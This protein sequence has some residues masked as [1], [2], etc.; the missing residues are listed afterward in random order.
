ME[1]IAEAKTLDFGTG[2][3]YFLA[4]DKSNS[5]VA[6]NTFKALLRGENSAVEMSYVN[7]WGQE[8][9]DKFDNIKKYLNKLCHPMFDIDILSSIKVPL[10]TPASLVSGEEL[11]IKCGLPKKSLNGLPVLELC[12]V[13][14]KCYYL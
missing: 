6:A 13:W 4:D 1:R 9:G 12:R 7:T 14:K 3:A 8:D 2:A 5:I 10:V 11:V